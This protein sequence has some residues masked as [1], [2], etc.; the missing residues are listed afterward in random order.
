MINFH[1]LC[2]SQSNLFSSKYLP[3]HV[4]RNPIISPLI[5]FPLLP[6][7]KIFIFFLIYFCLCWVFVAVPGLSLVVARKGYS[8]VV[9]LGLLIVLGSVFAACGLSCPMACRRFLDQ[10]LNPC[11]LH[12]QVVS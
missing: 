3:F 12:W 7:L 8:L 11:L 5:P 9:I 2:T 4:S 6:F 10:G 1:Q